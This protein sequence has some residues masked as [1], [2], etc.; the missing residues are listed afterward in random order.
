[1]RRESAPNG[2][3]RIDWN[4]MTGGALQMRKRA[5]VPY[6]RVPVGA[7]VLGGSGRIYLGCTVEN[8][9]YGLTLCAERSAVAQAIAAGEKTI[10]ACAVAVPGKPRAPCGA[11][12]QVLV[13]FGE[14][15]MP[16]VLVGKGKARLIHTLADLLAHPF[17]K[18]FL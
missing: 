11:C 8:A 7:A 10:V 2:P 12:R 13:E 14:P 3:V 18:S 6:S 16:V 9:S 15:S 17:D 5:Y 1:M 4:A